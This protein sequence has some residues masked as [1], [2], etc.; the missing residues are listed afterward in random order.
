M[1]VKQEVAKG[2]RVAQ[3]IHLGDY[4]PFAIKAKQ[5]RSSSRNS[6]RKMTGHAQI[7]SRRKPMVRIRKLVLFVMRENQNQSSSGNNGRKMTGHAQI[8]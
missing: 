8:V 5:D 4:V 6:G 2:R 7:V 3:M 1:M